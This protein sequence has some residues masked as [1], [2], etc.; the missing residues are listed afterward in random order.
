MGEKQVE[1]V[2]CDFTKL[3]VFIHRITY[4]PASFLD[5]YMYLNGSNIGL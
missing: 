2:Y 5:V 1:S 4:L 3:P